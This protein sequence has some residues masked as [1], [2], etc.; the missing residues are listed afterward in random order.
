MQ[1]LAMMMH[2]TTT[3]EQSYYKQI[4]EV[5]ANKIRTKFT[6]NEYNQ[7]AS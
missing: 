6:H 2:R 1:E 5:G 4:N 3:I 7:L